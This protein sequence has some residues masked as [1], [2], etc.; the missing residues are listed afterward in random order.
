MSL[1]SYQEGSIA[2]V[3]RAKGPDVWVYRY[4]A[5]A[6]EHGER[7]HASRVLG[8]VKQYPRKADAKKAA[9]NLRSEI[10]ATQ[11][12]VGRVTVNDAWGHFQVHEL[13]NPN[14]NRSPTTINGYLDYMKNWIL[15]QWKDVPLEDV[16]A[17]GVENWLASIKLAP[18]SKAKIRNYFSSLYS[19]CIRHE[20]FTKA[21]PIASVRQSAKRLKEPEIFSV[22]EMAAIISRV[23]NE[24]VRVMVMIAAASALRRSEI[25]GLKWKDV[26]L[27]GSWFHLERGYVRT[28]ET[29]LKTE[30]SRRGL[31]MHPELAVV[32]KAWRGKTPY[33]MDDD[34]V[35]ASPYT[36]G[37]R[38]YWPES[39]MVD[40]VRPAAKAAGITK[41]VNWHGFRHSLGTLMK[42]NG[43]DVKTIQELLRHANS[44]IT[45]DVY[46]QGD[47][48]TKRSALSGVS[49]IF[50]LKKSA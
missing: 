48:P 15:P 36:E 21:N 11:Q 32:L 27:D 50:L 6:D 17:V 40:Y 9:E 20:L 46:T 26:D 5:A 12:H 23:K 16:K 8:T 24:A 45:L 3:K 4:R 30:A 1:T 13:R 10:N 19:H 29:N 44:R 47:T 34:W 41:H 49:G 37:K 22:D 43:E 35:F 31:P 42:T 28:F 33:P 2:R 7:K 18:G 39:A 14:V 38:P 25:R